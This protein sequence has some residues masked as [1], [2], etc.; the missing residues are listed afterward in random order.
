MPT[1]IAVVREASELQVQQIDP[2]A[3]AA[4]DSHMATN[5]GPS[6][7]YAPTHARAHPPTFVRSHTLTHARKHSVSG[8]RRRRMGDG[9]EPLLGGEV[10]P[11]LGGEVIPLL[12][13]TRS[14]TVAR[15]C[16]TRRRS[17]PKASCAL[18]A[19]TP[20]VRAHTYVPTGYPTERNVYAS[21]PSVTAADVQTHA[22]SFSAD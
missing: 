20:S 7:L 8:V 5:F 16:W 15:R 10:I 3:D 22:M 9:G 2:G 17:D 6:V 12:G 11:L 19:G 21:K 1:P 14:G 13:G 18:R 4:V